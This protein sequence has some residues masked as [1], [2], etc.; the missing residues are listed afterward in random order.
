MPKA[1]RRVTRHPRRGK[2]LALPTM[3][4]RSITMLLYLFGFLTVTYVTL[5]IVTVCYAT[6]QTSL[7]AMVRDTEGSITAIETTYYAT[8]AR[9]HAASPE[10]IG[11]VAPA[12][13]EYATAPVAGLSLQSR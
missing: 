8:I 9:Q 2:A 4:D 7:A 10:S 13:V 5:V 12:H 3:P 11:L 1:T 6:W